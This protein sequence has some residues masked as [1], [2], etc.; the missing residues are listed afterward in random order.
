MKAKFLV[1]ANLPRYFKYFDSQHFEF[2]SDID[3]RMSDQRIWDYARE[4][5]LIILTKDSDFYTRCVLSAKPV[6]VIHFQFGNYTL[7][8]LH[9]FFDKNWK[10]ISE[11]IETSTLLI[12]GENEIRVVL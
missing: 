9:L 11:K 6:K 7:H 3:P 2:V 4:Q 8:Q 5:G 12:V 1:D 10:M